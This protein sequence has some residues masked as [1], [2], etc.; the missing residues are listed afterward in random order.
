MRKRDELRGPSCMTNALD[1]E[2]VFVLLG[3]DAAAP[4]AIRAWAEARIA[5]GLNERTDEKIVEAF[6][7]AETME[8]EMTA[9]ALRAAEE[10][11][12]RARR[13]PRCDSPDPKRHPAMQ[14][15][16]EVQICPDSFHG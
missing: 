5:L 14:F 1:D 13:C 9:T 3:R 12:K 16:G 11:K 8:L 4:L 15:E 2:M 10:K 6:K 7:C